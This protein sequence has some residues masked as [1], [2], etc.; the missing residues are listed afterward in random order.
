[1]LN[2]LLKCSFIINLVVSHFN[3][4]GSSINVI[5]YAELVDAYVMYCLV[6]FVC[7]V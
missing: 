5:C 7:L 2:F 3:V 1:M 6:I 4:P